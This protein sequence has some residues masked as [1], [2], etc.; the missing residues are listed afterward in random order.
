MERHGSVYEGEILKKDVFEKRKREVT[1][2]RTAL[3]TVVLIFWI[4]SI[5][6]MVYYGEAIEFLR[7]DMV[8]SWVVISQSVILVLVFLSLYRGMLFRKHLEKKRNA[9][10][11]LH[12]NNL[13]IIGALCSNYNAVYFA[14]LFTEE[15]T[16]LMAG[17]RI[18]D[19]MGVDYVEESHSIEWYANAY[20]EKMLFEED[21]EAFLKEV[22]GENLREK[23]K[24]REYYTYNYVGNK[25][26]K[27]NF[28][29][30]KA[31]KVNGSE[32]MLVVGFADVDSEVREELEKQ[33]LLQDALTQTMEANNTKDLV[34]S[35]IITRIMEPVNSIVEIAR[36]IS[37]NESNTD[38]VRSAGNHILMETENLGILFNDIMEMNRLRNEQFVI[39][40]G[41][42]D[43][44][45]ILDTVYGAISERAKE[46]KVTLFFD[47]DISHERVIGDEK[48][49]TTIFQHM[50]NIAMDY[51][52]E[53]CSLHFLASETGVVDNKASFEFV[54]L[55][56]GN[57]MDERTK[58][59][60]LNEQSFDEICMNTNVN[61]AIGLSIS[62]QII[63]LMGGKLEIDSAEQQ[64]MKITAKISLNI[65]E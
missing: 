13:E 3:F 42:A 36:M 44:N 62:R 51:C 20:S 9:Q 6:M 15:V 33:N 54:V 26:G 28:F 56:H 34:I 22:N 41:K 18:R 48:R 12:I 17:G 45:K 19:N 52:Y 14:N 29:Q 49:L 50:V 1:Y 24:D 31:A 11:R 4:V 35:D 58:N 43:I 37:G 5:G 7:T 21:R 2:L 39:K 16:V 38:S 23:L 32:N 46:K 63:E 61:S 27:K 60:I 53:D 65:Y 59:T 8:M 57:G 30:M 10:E 55:N 25:N 47:R 40:K 64:G